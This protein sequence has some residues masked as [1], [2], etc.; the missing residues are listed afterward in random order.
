MWNASTNPFPTNPAYQS[1]ADEILHPRLPHQVE[2]ET[3]IAAE[4][5][6]KADKKAAQVSCM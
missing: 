6:K 2:K 5:K 4:K 3:K 1:P